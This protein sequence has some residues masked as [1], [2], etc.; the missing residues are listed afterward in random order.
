VSTPVK[1]PADIDVEDKILG[2]LTARQL[3]LFAA[4]G[5]VLYTAWR[6]GQQ[7]V[8]WPVLTALALLVAAGVAVLVLGHRDGVSLDRL[9]LAAVRQHL[10]PRR[11]VATGTG[12]VPDWITAHASSASGTSPGEAAVGIGLPAEEVSDTGVVDLGREG[13]AVVA[14]CS[15]VN[16]A[17]RTPGEQD[18][19]V[20][21][22]ARWLHS[23]TA[24]AQLL[25]RAER[26]D[27][28]GQIAEL[29]QQAPRLP[30]PAL[31]AAARE[32]ADY[33]HELAAG[34]QLLRRQVL[35]VLR[36]PRALV[37]TR[38]GGIAGWWP[39]RRREPARPQ[40]QAE[41]R[42]A[43]ARL[44]RRLQEAADLLHPAGITVTPLDAAQATSVLASACNPDR[45]V[46]GSADLADPGEVIT[47]PRTD[48]DEEQS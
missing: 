38:T 26:L 36:E 43:E 29:D 34:S 1:I 18:A 5:L 45:L 7:W 10:Q 23:L 15:T 31:T 37:P 39:G 12:P 42:A 35:L 8:P 40:G 19:L 16:F 48:E 3:G 22:F 6:A 9:L 11:R 44:S 24:P 30:H 2:P 41:R 4:T 32:H 27:V 17:L 14:A 28:S 46:P 25:V 47:G 21:V 20:A 13:L 33:L